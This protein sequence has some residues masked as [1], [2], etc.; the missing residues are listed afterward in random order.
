MHSSATLLGRTADLRTNVL[1]LLEAVSR[2]G[3][4]TA[5]SARLVTHLQHVAN[6]LGAAERMLL[7]KPAQRLAA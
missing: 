4:A 2:D 5:G 7:Q 3:A 6:D 1:D